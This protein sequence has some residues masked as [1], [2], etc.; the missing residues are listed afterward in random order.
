MPGY[1]DPQ[2]LACLQP[3]IEVSQRKSQQKPTED[4][5]MRYMILALSLPM[6]L[7]AAANVTTAQAASRS[8]SAAYHPGCS[9]NPYSP[10][11]QIGGCGGGAS[12]KKKNALTKHHTTSH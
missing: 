1:E 12:A 5:T 6:F 11:F 8:S 7:L 4:S 9:T 2:R 10:K 3:A